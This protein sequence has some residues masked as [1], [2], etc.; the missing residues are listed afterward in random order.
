MHAVSNMNT[1]CS[2][3]FI[4]IAKNNFSDSKEASKLA[5]MFNVK[6]LTARPLDLL[7]H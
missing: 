6:F 3:K 1:V 4:A 5:K 2:I 7:H